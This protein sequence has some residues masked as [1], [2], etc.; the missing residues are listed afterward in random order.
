MGTLV[1]RGVTSFARR[2]RVLTGSYLFGIVVLLFMGAGTQ[3]TLQQRREYNRI[4]NTI[5]LRAE[6][7]ASERYARAYQNYQATKG[8]FFSCDS[9]CQRNKQAMD[10]A[11]QEL[12]AVREEGN[13][14]VSDAKAV[15]NLFS[16]V[17]VDE[18]KESFWN[19]FQSGKDF[20]KRQNMWD[21]MFM[22]IRH[23]S[24]DESTVEYLLR[25]SMQVL[26]NFSVG[27]LMA[28]GF[29]AFGLW[30]II[31]N[32]RANPVVAVAL[33]V[34]AALAAYSFVVMYLLAIYGATAGG[35]YEIAKLAQTSQNARNQQERQHQYMHN[36]PHYDRFGFG[37]GLID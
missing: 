11:K 33:F 5:D 24:R 8:W 4:M 12:D 1:V 29:F 23:M 3:L 26:V 31:S 21:A 18:V 13:A 20:A 15:A 2:N 37:N 36:R 19:Y 7:A 6:Y 22:G 9:L 16:E 17:G 32:Y 10:Q 34:C 27:L 28:L 35:L 30:S 25:V 14:H